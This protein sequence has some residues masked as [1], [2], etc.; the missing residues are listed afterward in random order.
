MTGAARADLGDRDAGGGALG[1]GRGTV[2]GAGPD[3]EVEPVDGRGRAKAGA[4][5]TEGMRGAGP[6]MRG[7]DHP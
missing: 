7:G 5:S 3:R 6:E 1:D 2:L 4:S